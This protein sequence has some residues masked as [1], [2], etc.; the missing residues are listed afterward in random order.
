MVMACVSQWTSS[1][2][3]VFVLMLV[4]PKGYI[5]MKGNRK[6]QICISIFAD[7]ANI[8]VTR[9]VVGCCKFERVCVCVCVFCMCSVS[10]MGA[11]PCV[12]ISKL[13]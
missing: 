2:H 12:C 5:H 7:V 4:M 1:E 13:C 9:P 11:H 3:P 10:K 6:Y 8:C